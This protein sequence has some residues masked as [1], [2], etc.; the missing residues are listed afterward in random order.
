MYTFVPAGNNMKTE[1]N[2]SSKLSYLSHA[3]GTGATH[4]VFLMAK[5]RH[6]AGKEI[7][8]AASVAQLK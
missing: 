7:R 5:R 3:K 6:L 8:A 1:P 2:E 4:L